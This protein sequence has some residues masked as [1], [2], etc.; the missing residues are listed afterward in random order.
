MA[1]GAVGVAPARISR[2]EEINMR[3]HSEYNE[4][5]LERQL[6]PDLSLLGLG[7]LKILSSQRSQKNGGRLD[8][9]AEDRANESLYVIEFMLGQLD[10]GHLVRVLDYWLREKQRNT[11]PDWDVIPVVVAEDV[12]DSRYY[13]VAQY[14][15]TRLPLVAVEMTA[16]RVGK[17]L[18]L[19]CARL[20]DGRDQLD[21]E[22][23]DVES[24]DPKTEWKEKLTPECLRAILKIETVLRKID[25]KLRLNW[26]QGFVGILAGNKVANFVYLVPKLKFI[27]MVARLYDE[28]ETWGKKLKAAGFELV[29]A[30]GKSVRFRMPFSFTGSQAKVIRGVIERAYNLRFSGEE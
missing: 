6:I 24:G 14:L 4:A 30:P 27:R 26:R 10:A 23:P 9:I 13:N 8:V 18:I 19:N 20:L 12:R 7:S 17:R 28:S 11:H 22:A 29:G 25:S 21:A 5:W 1:Y 16:L 2:A 15:S 3:S